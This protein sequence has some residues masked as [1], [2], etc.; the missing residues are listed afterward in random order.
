MLMRNVD[1]L[2]LGCTHYPIIKRAI[3]KVAGPK[4]RLI[5]SAE[6]C[7]E[8]VARRLKH[9]HLLRPQEILIGQASVGDDGKTVMTAQ[10]KQTGTLRSFVTDDAAR[11]ATLASRFL[12]FSIEAPMPVMPD[13]LYS[14]KN[15]QPMRL[16]VSA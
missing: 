12:G 16:R 11:F 9:K 8:D 6:Q 1:V 10:P 4:I 7:A 2:V 5:D 13:E 15:S 14:L 3:G